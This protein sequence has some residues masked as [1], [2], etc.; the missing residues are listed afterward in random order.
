MR[1]QNMKADNIIGNISSVVL[2]VLVFLAGLGALGGRLENG[3]VGGIA[4]FVSVCL[5]IPSRVYEQRVARPIGFLA[6]ILATAASVNC[7]AFCGYAVYG[8]LSDLHDEFAL[9]VAAIGVGGLMAFVLALSCTCVMLF[10]L[11]PRP[12][13]AAIGIATGIAVGLLHILLVY[14][15][16]FQD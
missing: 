9:L 8:F 4:L 13:H 2:G 12:A 10:K 3:V 5:F 15:V 6:L 16:Y 1:S 11:R 14:L 7:A